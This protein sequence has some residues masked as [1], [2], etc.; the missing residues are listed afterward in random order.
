MGYGD[1][2]LYR[3]KFEDEEQVSVIYTGQFFLG[4]TLQKKQNE[5]YDVKITVTNTKTNYEYLY[6]PH[7]KT[8]RYVMALPAGTYRL[9][10][11]ARGYARHK[12][13][14]VV[15]DMGRVNLERQKDIHLRKLN[16]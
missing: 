2:D 6:I 12:E 16:K 15:S 3:V 13:D 14:L 8:G 4:D 1:L 7:S 10:T 5:N 9:T 11:H